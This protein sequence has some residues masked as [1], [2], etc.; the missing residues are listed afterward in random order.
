MYNKEYRKEIDKKLADFELEDRDIIIDLLK[1]IDSLTNLGT[2]MA[3]DY[4]DYDINHNR[5]C[6][7]CLGDDK[8]PHSDKCV[9]NNWNKLATR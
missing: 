1:H 5:F 4:F 2:K 3:N 9:V 8:F 7:Y 6:T